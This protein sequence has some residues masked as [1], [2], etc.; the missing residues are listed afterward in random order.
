MERTITFHCAMC[1]C[2]HKT[3]NVKL[4]SQFMKV[5]SHSAME[6]EITF[7]KK[8]LDTRLYSVP[9]I[10]CHNSYVGIISTPF[11]HILNT[12]H[13]IYDHET[14]GNFYLHFTEM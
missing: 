3:R 12:C 5:I 10:T 8:Y 4:L 13:G 2:S 1:N 6:S 7:I 9:C 11:Q 14:P